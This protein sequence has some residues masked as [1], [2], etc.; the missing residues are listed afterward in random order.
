V[1]SLT[2]QL[3]CVCRDVRIYD[4]G[5]TDA[6]TVLTTWSEL[7][8]TTLRGV[9]RVLFYGAPPKE[10]L[11][12]FSVWPTDILVL[13]LAGEAYARDWMPDPI[14]LWTRMEEANLALLQLPHHNAPYE[15]IEA[16]VG[17]DHA[18]LSHPQSQS[19]RALTTPPPS[20]AEATSTDTT[21]RH[22]TVELISDSD[23][24]EDDG[25]DDVF[26]N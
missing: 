16:F 24:G 2:I 3:L 20:Y 19:E 18:I 21:R 23:E 12:M 13:L 4:A 15:S 1:F 5:V 26:F 14:H 9:D 25:D 7:I 8:A 17:N 11:S 22:S 6:T 10:L